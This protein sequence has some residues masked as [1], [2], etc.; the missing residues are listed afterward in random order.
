[1]NRECK[2]YSRS[3]RSILA[4]VAIVATFRALASIEELATGQHAACAYRATL[5]TE[6][7]GA[8]RRRPNRER[9]SRRRNVPNVG[10]GRGDRRGQVTTSATFHFGA[11]IR[12][13]GSWPASGRPRSAFSGS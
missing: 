3:A 12:V 10:S 5:T 1:M 6:A 13:V 9:L 8:W 4:A 11:R 7:Y 2:P